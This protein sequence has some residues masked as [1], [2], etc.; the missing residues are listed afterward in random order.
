MV[1]WIPDGQPC[2]SN[3]QCMRACFNGVC[4]DAPTPIPTPDCT[5][6]LEPCTDSAEC[7][8]GKCVTEGNQRI[9]GL[10]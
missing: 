1:C 10:V 2:T 3:D 6:L 8:Q 5:Q 9:C 7:C 4:G